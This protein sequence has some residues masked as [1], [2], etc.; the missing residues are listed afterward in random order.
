MR[1]VIHLVEHA[2]REARADV[3][4]DA[5]VRVERGLQLQ[6]REVAQV[7]HRLVE[8]AASWRCRVASH[9]VHVRRWRTRLIFD[10]DVM[11]G[12]FWGAHTKC[13]LRMLQA[14]QLWC[15]I[16]TPVRFPHDLPLRTP[17][18]TYNM[19]HIRQH[20][21][22]TN[23]NRTR[24]AFRGSRA[25]VRRP[26]ARDG[27]IAHRRCGLWGMA[28]WLVGGPHAKQRSAPRAAR[29]QL[30]SHPRA[31][32]REAAADAR[33]PRLPRAGER[34][35]EARTSAPQPHATRSDRNAHLSRDARTVTSIR[36]RQSLT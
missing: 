36:R 4:Q 25:A 35:S 31:P 30:V 10:D 13:E 19:N 12:C 17:H 16:H 33:Q 24:P 1:E 34:C 8:R 2:V 21:P 26:A 28:W 9:S 20:S 15:T 27:V 3:R 32:L 7:A 18:G 23:P 14:L 11:I 29:A 6:A 22:T 5:A